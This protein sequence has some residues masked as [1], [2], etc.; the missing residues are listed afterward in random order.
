[1]T[2]GINVEVLT[3]A[4]LRNLARAGYSLHVGAEQDGHAQAPLLLAAEAR[5][6]CYGLNTA[7]AVG[8]IWGLWCV[9][10]FTNTNFRQHI[11]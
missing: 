4:L 1:M 7:S 8:H 2:N 3:E 6:R 5:R 11:R 9:Q 10:G